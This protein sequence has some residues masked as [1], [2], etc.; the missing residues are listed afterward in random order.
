MKIT[1]KQLNFMKRH[2]LYLCGYDNSDLKNLSSE[3]IY[4]LYLKHK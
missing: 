2:L 1:E 3:E 4:K